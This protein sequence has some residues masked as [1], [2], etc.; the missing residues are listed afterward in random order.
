[1]IGIPVY[2]VHTS[3]IESMEAVAAARARGQIAFS[4][5]LGSR[6]EGCGNGCIEGIVPAEGQLGSVLG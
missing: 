3:A 5:V 1:M 6:T 2:I 4:E